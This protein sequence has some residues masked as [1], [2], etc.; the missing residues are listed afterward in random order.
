VRRAA[1]RPIARALE[2]FGGSLAPPTLLARVQA[3]WVDAAGEAVAREAEPVAEREGTVTVRCSSSVWASEL[4][5]LSEDLLGRL[6]SRLAAAGERPAVKA[7]RFVTGGR[8]G[9]P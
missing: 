6:N 5:L 3:R 4:Q 2:G 1:P 9:G 7:L 8:P